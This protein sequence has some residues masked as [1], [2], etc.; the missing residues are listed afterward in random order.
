[1]GNGLR[2]HPYQKI[3]I[4]SVELLESC[5]LYTIFALPVYTPLL[6][7]A[8][9]RRSECSLLHCFISII[10]I[11][12]F[13]DF[14]LSSMHTLMPL[15]PNWNKTYLTQLYRTIIN[16][17]DNEYQYLTNERRFYMGYL[18]NKTLNK[19]CFLCI[20]KSPPKTH[21]V[22]NNK[23]RTNMNAS[24]G[25]IDWDMNFSSREITIFHV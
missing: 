25:F 6:P 20:Q 2:P 1:M 24:P 23:K 16:R 22:L 15:G 17:H 7:A 10:C 21:N 9:S 4:K 8:A 13:K 18:I 14:S 19:Q 12:T 5:L 11:N 3:R